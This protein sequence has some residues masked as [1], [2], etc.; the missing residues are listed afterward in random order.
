MAIA[1]PAA[2]FKGE[3]ILALHRREDETITRHASSTSLIVATMSFSLFFFFLTLTCI[4]PRC[5]RS[6][7]GD[8]HLDACWRG[9]AGLQHSS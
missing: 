8:S 6:S 3:A 2:C 7:A 4:M 5:R 1:T 9:V